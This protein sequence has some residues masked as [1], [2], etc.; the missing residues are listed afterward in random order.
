MPQL[1]EDDAAADVAEGAATLV[2]GQRF[3]ANLQVKKH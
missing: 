2:A 1:C 3:L